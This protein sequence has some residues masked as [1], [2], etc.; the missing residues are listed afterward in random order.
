MSEAVDNFEIRPPADIERSLF[1]EWRS[2]RRGK[3]HPHE[4]T[5]D[6]WKW[7]IE[8]KLPDDWIHERLSAYQA[9]EAFDG[10]GSMNAGPCW[11]FDRFGQTRTVLPD[12]R[13]V[14]VAGEHEDFYDPD[15][16][17]YND[18]VIVDPSGDVR[19][20]GYPID[21][22]PPTD[23]HSATLVDNAIILIGNLSYSKNRRYGQT[24]VLRLEIDTWRISSIET[25][26][27]S[28][29]W[30]HR[31]KAEP[32]PDRNEIRIIGGEI[33]R[34]DNTSLVENIDDWTLDCRTWHW[35]RL[36]RRQWT[37]FE[38]HRKDEKLNHLS[39]IR[40]LLF[41]KQ[42]A[43]R[44]REYEKE[45]EDHE[46]E[47]RYK[48]GKQILCAWIPAASPDLKLLETLYKPSVATK[49]IEKDVNE[50]D[51]EHD[52]YRIRVGDVCVRYVEDMHTITVTIEGELPSDIVQRI[53]DDVM[54]KFT[55]LEGV[56]VV[57]RDISLE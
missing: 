42:M 8:T 19:I 38:L 41:W 56:P 50:D 13:M 4:M 49:I 5:N 3:E 31:H 36:S 46:K 52:V 44:S 29:G 17:I 57:C 24:Q 28:P 10:P 6:V 54:K 14:Y 12:G 30:I 45:Y 2:P 18:V 26:G 27:D 40:Q 37:R 33:D 7:L 9:D 21:V 23:F 35:N 55:A 22:F 1:L 47:L 39:D 15:F 16:Y 51:D 25:S 43:E 32:S 20:F 48:L 53:K 11:C 34:G